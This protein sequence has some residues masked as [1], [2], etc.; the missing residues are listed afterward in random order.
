[1]TADDDSPSRLLIPT[2]VLLTTVT[3]VVSSLGAPLVPTIAAELGVSLGAAQWTLTVSMLAG[4]VATPLMGRVAVGARRRP[5]V[6]GGLLLVVAGTVLSAAASRYD[7]DLA[8]ALLI[9]GR[10]GQGIALGLAPLAMAVARETLPAARVAPV[11]A[12][13]SVGTVAGAGLGYPLTALVAQA[14]GLSAAFWF[15]TALTA[16][17]LLLTWRQLPAS[18]PVPVPGVRLSEAVLLSAATVALL[19]GVSQ[20]TTW[21]WTD[22]RTLSLF[23]VGAVTLAGWVATTLRHRDP[24]VDLRLAFSG[25][26]AAPNITGLLAGTGMYMGLTLLMVLVQADTPSGWGLDQPVA[27]AGLMLVPYSLMSVLGSRVS[28]WAGTRMDPGKVLPVGCALYLLSTVQLAVAHD[29]VWHALL[30]MA[31]AGLGSGATFATLPVL[32]VRAVP[33]AQT[34]SA[35]AFNQVLRY[36]GFSTGSAV[37]VTVLTLVSGPVPDEHGF[38]AAMAVN[39]AVWVLAIVVV[40][41]RVRRDTQS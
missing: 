6:L 34:S 11:V 36:I 10:A 5:V 4:A 1:M 9:A 29:Q 32:L 15:G 31:V 33:P 28:L 18:A 40:V 35:L 26:A 17:T 23:I 3:G 13:L 19:L 12:M 8:L 22:L 41:L 37:G 27:V 38:T 2:L 21:G 39:A 14:G 16:A 30:S 24:L 7:G 20:T 25:G